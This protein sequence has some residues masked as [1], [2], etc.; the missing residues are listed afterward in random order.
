MKLLTVFTISAFA[1]N[2]NIFSQNDNEVD[3]FL[4]D[5]VYRFQGII[6]PIEFQYDLHQFFQK[7]LVKQIPPNVL[8]SDNPSTIWLR[9][10]MMISE[11]SFFE[12]KIDSENHFTS[13][14]HELYLEDSEFDMFRYVLGMAQ[15]SAVAYMAYRHIKKYGFLK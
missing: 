1:F 15:L 5:T 14:L 11:Q 4:Q 3:F 8:F 6:P 13:S 10:E 9:T 2:S 7:P 12:K